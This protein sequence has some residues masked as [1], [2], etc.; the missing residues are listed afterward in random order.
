MGLKLN[1]I[2]TKTKSLNFKVVINKEKLQV[3]L[4]DQRGL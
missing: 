2:N 1:F 3:N 4:N